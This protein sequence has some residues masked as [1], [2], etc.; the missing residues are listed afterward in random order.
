MCKVSIIIP[1]YNRFSFLKQAVESVLSQTFS[2]F[3]LIIVDDGSID[4]TGKIQEIFQHGIKYIFQEN[5]GV[6]SAR[7]K[8]IKK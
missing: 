5:K 2:D 3:E 7:N 6:S 4:E 8:G 1:T